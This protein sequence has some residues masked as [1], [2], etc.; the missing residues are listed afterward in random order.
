VRKIQELRR[1]E[2]HGPYTG[3]VG[4]LPWNFRIHLGG[5]FLLRSRSR[6]FK[7]HARELTALAC[8][9]AR[10]AHLDQ[11]NPSVHGPAHAGSVTAL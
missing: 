2:N 6:W 8:E 9:E 1:S 3:P 7:R 5:R 4:T 11:S 10:K